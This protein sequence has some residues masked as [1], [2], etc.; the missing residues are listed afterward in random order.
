MTKQDED[1][2]TIS[3]GQICDILLVL[4]NLLVPL[5]LEAQALI[6]I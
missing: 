5:V 6:S 4:P 3:H 2:K 1:R